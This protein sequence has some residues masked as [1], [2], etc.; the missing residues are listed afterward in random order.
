MMRMRK[1]CPVMKKI[2]LLLALMLMMTM[3]MTGCQSKPAAAPTAAPTATT[4]PA[5][6][7]APAA[8]PTEAPAETAETVA[9]ADEVVA[10]VNGVS[11]YAS[12]VAMIADNLMYQ[13]A[14]YGYDTSDPSFA[15][16]AQEYALQYAL[17]L[18]VMMQK[19]AEKGLD[20]FTDEEMASMTADAKTEWE[21]LVEQYI[22]YYGGLTAESTDADKAAARES[23]VAML[24]T[25]GATEESWLSDTVKNAILER[26]EAE[27]VQGA[28]VTDEEVV[29]AYNEKV[30]AD[31]ATYKTDAATYEYMTQYYGQTAYYMPE[32]YRGIT[33]ILLNVD[34]TL[35][36]TW[37]DLTAKLEEQEEAA[38][39]TE[40]T[41][42]AETAE[43]TAEPT[44]PV[45]QEE[46]DAAYQ[47]VLDS[48]KTTTDE[49]YAALEAGTPFADLIAKYNTDPGMQNEPYAS[50]GY[51][52]H[53]DSIMWD[54]AFTQAAFSV[55]KVGDVA[56]PV[57][58]SYGVHIVCYHRDVPSGAIELTEELK[59]NLRA[60]LI[61]TKEGELF[62]NTMAAWM[63]EAK[64]EYTAVPAAET[65]E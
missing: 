36:N 12:D 57:V 37:K 43:A 28:V 50:E 15:A 42:G 48:V 8:D 61:S 58:G 60:E 16:S 41:E 54:P 4:A 3:V 62:N 29:S 6:T 9:P 47:A 17:Q 14:Q 24:G 25:M 18:E 13:Y 59:N 49:I 26:I 64:I 34:E 46:V 2:A 40:A 56:Q 30:T 1:E 44:T 39:G 19:A 35:L 38:E 51:S 32:G 53:K 5:A 7:E 11:V 55:E 27:M 23:I 33:H 31:E 63:E 52:V 65:A 20:K 10:T 21:A 22:A 45:T